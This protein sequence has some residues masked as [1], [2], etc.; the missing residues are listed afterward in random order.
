MFQSDPFAI[1]PVDGSAFYAFKGVE[2]K[3]I[4]QCG[5]N[6]GWVRDC[7]GESVSENI[8]VDRNVNS[9]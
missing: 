9:I 6:G 1:L 7:F 4:S 2:T 5:W 8:M 3:V